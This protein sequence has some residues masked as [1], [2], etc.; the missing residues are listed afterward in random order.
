MK[1]FSALLLVAL[2]LATAGCKKEQGPQGEQG[3]QGEQGQQGEAGPNAK[4][5]DFTLT[6][7]TSTTVQTYNMPS[8]SMY[9][10]V[11]FVYLDKGYKDWV[12]LPYYENNPGFLPVNYIAT[13]DEIMERIEIRTD[14]GDNQTGSPWAVNNV[15]RNFRAVVLE[16]SGFIQNPDVD[17]KD[18]KQVEKALNL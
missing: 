7:G 15:Q 3:I 13:C 10:K 9:G 12:M 17:W 6:F 1:R 14:R 4:V 2:A 18:Y 8:Q 11:T 5:Y 16:I